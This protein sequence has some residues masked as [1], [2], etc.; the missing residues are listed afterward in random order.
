MELLHTVHNAQ[1]E[2]EYVYVFNERL[3]HQETEANGNLRLDLDTALVVVLLYN[4]CTEHL[5]END[6]TV[7]VSVWPSSCWSGLKFWGMIEAA[8]AN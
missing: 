4:T 6:S 8:H 1:W 3:L 2:G 7:L 5:H